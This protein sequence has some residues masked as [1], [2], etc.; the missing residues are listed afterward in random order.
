MSEDTALRHPEFSM[1]EQD[2]TKAKIIWERLTNVEK[3]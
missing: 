3:A 1:H 2:R